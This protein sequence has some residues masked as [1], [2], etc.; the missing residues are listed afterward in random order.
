MSILISKPAKI[1]IL[2]LL[3][4]VAVQIIIFSSIYS[5]AQSLYGLEYQVKAGFIYNFAKFTEWPKD[6]FDNDPNS[7]IL[8][9]IPNNPE[10]NVFFNLSNKKVGGKKIIIK[11]CND[12][13]DKD[14]EGCHILFFDSTDKNFIQESL[15]IVKYRSV[16]TV[17]HINGFT[18]DGGIINFFTEKGQLRF[19]ANLEAAR[20]ARIKLG[21]QLLMSAEVV[22]QDFK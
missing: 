19:K 11:K 7:I 2:S 10:T 14:V 5:H 9:I 6:T 16:L 22:Q 20:R 8:C 3:I 4:A 12:V 13:K 21:S 17:G 15:L 18:E 1:I